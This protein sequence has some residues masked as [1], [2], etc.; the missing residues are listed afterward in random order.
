MNNTMCPNGSSSGNFEA[1]AEQAL[2]PA[3]N[4]IPIWRRNVLPPTPVRGEDPYEF[5]SN[6][7]PALKRVRSRSKMSSNTSNA[8]RKAAAFGAHMRRHA[9][10]VL[11][12]SVS[13]VSRDTNQ[14]LQECSG[15][16]SAEV[17]QSV[18]AIADG[19]TDGTVIPDRT[20]EK[21]G[22]EKLLQCSVQLRQHPTSLP[23][24]KPRLSRM[25]MSTSD[26]RPVRKPV[27]I[28]PDVQI[29]LSA[30][31]LRTPKLMNHNRS[32]VN[33]RLALNS[34]G[35]EEKASDSVAKPTSNSSNGLEPRK[36]FHSRSSMNLRLTPER[37]MRERRM[38]EADSNIANSK[39]KIRHSVTMSDLRNGI[40]TPT[41]R[42]RSSLTEADSKK[43][44]LALRKR[45]SSVALGE[46]I[47]R[48]PPQDESDEITTEVH[49]DLEKTSIA[50]S[51]QLLEKDSQTSQS[52]D[53][54][55]SAIGNK[56]MFE[57]ASQSSSSVLDMDSS[58]PAFR[59][60]ENALFP[61]TF[62]TTVQSCSV[63]QSCDLES[64]GDFNKFKCEV[65][66]GKPHEVIVE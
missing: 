42:R 23:P 27:T 38:S 26:I 29:P 49:C 30:T 20:V 59:S 2:L 39:N 57:N 28:G 32:S 63:D 46:I 4:Q 3:P 17:K 54:H 9:S 44:P 65:T 10:S 13:D 66:E 45:S 22:S 40:S 36:L 41:R 24:K 64:A 60:N 35:G 6:L 21:R 50:A 16:E 11:L 1:S 62:A 51:Q 43:P 31:P 37:D 25:Y 5:P 8:M 55:V 18:E 52:L 47:P 33:L 48:D 14:P 7:T 15:S 53:T 61:S 12:P 34:D 58:T 19:N 56:K